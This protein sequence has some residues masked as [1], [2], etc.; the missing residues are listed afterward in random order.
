[1]T[2][3]QIQQYIA[4]ITQATQQQLGQVTGQ[5][6]SRGLGGSSIEANAMAQNQA[7]YQQNVLQTG[8][9]IGQQQQQNQANALIGL[10]GQQFGAGQQQ[11]GLGAQYAGLAQGSAGQQSDLSS[12]IAGLP[13]Q[14]TNQALGQN[15]ALQALRP[16]TTS[17]LG[18]Y[19][20]TGLG[21]LLGG[22]MGANYGGNIASAVTGNPMGANLGA[23][24]NPLSGILGTNQGGNSTSG[25]NSLGNVNILSQLMKAYGGLGGGTS[26]A[27]AGGGTA[28][29]SGI[30]S[31]LMAI[32]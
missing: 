18:G 6:A 4:P 28:T 2:P 12:L 19:L 17:P 10:G 15:A 21:F 31:G 27:A 5:M 25:M 9:G 11:Y 24:I 32:A 3:D 7:L 13:S 14:F 8:L 23:A 16:Q 26:A 1:M 30:T 20:G 22:P 29:T